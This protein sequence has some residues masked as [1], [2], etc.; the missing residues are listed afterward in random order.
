MLWLPNL[1]ITLFIRYGLP[2]S[3]NQIPISA[4][5]SLVFH[6]TLLHEKDIEYRLRCVFN[7]RQFFRLLPLEKPGIPLRIPGF[8]VRMFDCLVIIHYF[9]QQKYIYT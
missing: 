4:S 9:C 6:A 3:L 7:S 2:I 8:L 5:L 1:T